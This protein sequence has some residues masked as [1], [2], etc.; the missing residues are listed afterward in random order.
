M[1]THYAPPIDRFLAAERRRR[2][3]RLLARFR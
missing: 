2:W 1:Y 3:F